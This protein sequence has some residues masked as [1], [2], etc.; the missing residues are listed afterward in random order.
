MRKER[1][2]ANQVVVYPW[3]AMPI[4]SPFTSNRRW[5]KAGVN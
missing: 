1:Q 5:L 4:V 2:V 3:M